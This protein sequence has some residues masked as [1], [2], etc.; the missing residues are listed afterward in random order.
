MKKPAPLPA[1]LAYRPFTLEESQVAGVSRSRTRRRDLWVP[2][3]SIRIPIAVPEP[4]LER[5][6]AHVA[7]TPGSV[8]SHVSAARLHGL[9]LPYRLEDD[10]G[11][12]LACSHA[13]GNPR[14]RGVRGH[15]LELLATDIVRVKE[16]PVT[17]LERTFLDLA[18]V[19][20]VDE[21]VTVGDQLICAH[22][23]DYRP[24]QLPRVSLPALRSYVFAHSGARGMKKLRAALELVRIG[25]DSPRETKLRLIIERSSLPTFEPNV[26]LLDTQNIA[27]IYPDLGCE[28]YRTCA[29][30]DGDHH[31]SPEQIGKDHDRNFITESLGWRQVIL[32]KEDFRLGER[33]ILAKIARKLV[34]A[35]WSDPENL[36]GT[37]L[38]GQLGTRK[39]FN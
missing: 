24:P 11:V 21:L 26:V 12:D 3:R 20:G 25:A 6:R 37:S 8:L 32:N 2:S 10:G 28:E 34:L 9:Y 18:T 4:G 39:D 29:E 5:F 38:R 17:S 35:G 15:R 30:Y 7:V 23:W 16:I 1:H 13:A 14:R 36:S 22:E 31:V 27:K 19:L 33:V